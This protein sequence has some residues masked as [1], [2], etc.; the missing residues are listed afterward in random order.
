MASELGLD[1]ELA[2][3]CG[4]LHDLGK[5]IDHEHERSHAVAAANL[6]R[7]YGEDPAVINA[8]EASHGEVAEASIY[9]ALTQLSD[10]LSAAR[11]G[12]RAD[13]LDGYLQRVRSLEALALGYDG[14][15]DAY[16]IQAGREI[17]VVVAPHLVSENAAEAITR[18]LRQ[19]IENELQ[20]PGTIKI[21]VIREQRF[22]TTA[23]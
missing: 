9:A 22:S 7:R 2:K 11:P 6:L 12:V 18:D 3:R 23:R 17:R 1:P 20:Y 15:R 10:S 21:T 8:V 13:S 5:A 19:Q 16:A 14:V 4:L